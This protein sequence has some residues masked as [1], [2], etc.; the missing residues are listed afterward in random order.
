MIKIAKIIE[1]TFLKK[2]MKR[3]V[4]SYNTL[5]HRNSCKIPHY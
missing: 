4:K 1:K 3:R 2:Y 5:D